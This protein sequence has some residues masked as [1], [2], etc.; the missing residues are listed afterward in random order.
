[1]DKIVND[2]ILPIL[3]YGNIMNTQLKSYHKISMFLKQH[4]EKIN[5]VSSEEDRVREFFSSQ[6]DIQG[7]TANKNAESI[8]AD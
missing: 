4:I 7:V 6:R 5:E 1:M 2:H 3:T 8:S